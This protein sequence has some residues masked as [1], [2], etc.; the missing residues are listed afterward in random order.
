MNLYGATETTMIKTIYPISRMDIEK[1]T[2]P[3]GKPIAGAR[4]IILDKYLLPCQDG[5]VG[6][7]FIRTPYR[8]FG[9]Y[10]NPELNIH[11]IMIQMILYTGLAI[12]GECYR[13][14]IWNY[15]GE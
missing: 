5:D 4:I 1:A 6:E 8:T 2:I 14:A 10:N 11:L 3:I 15:W 9:Y 7:L 12:W 13:M